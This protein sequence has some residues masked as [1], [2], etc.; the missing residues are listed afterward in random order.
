MPPPQQKKRR[1]KKVARKPTPCLPAWFGSEQN[2]IRIKN[3]PLNYPLLCCEATRKKEEDN[4]TPQ[5]TKI[6]YQA[7][8]SVFSRLPKILQ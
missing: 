1:R 3:K 8:S 5:D 7:Y 2:I 4:K 6:Q